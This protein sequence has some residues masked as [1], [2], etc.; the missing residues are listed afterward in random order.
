MLFVAAFLSANALL[1]ERTRANALAQLS[2]TNET[3]GGWF[4][5]YETLP[6]LYARNPRV[7]S[8]L[9]D[10]AGRDELDALNRELAEWNQI[11]GTSDTYLIARDGTTVAASNW[12]LITTFVG[13]NFSYRP[14]FADAISGRPGHF[15]G[16]G[17]TSGQRGYYLSAPIQRGDET[18]GVVVV[19]V[20]AA[21]L[22]RTLAEAAYP[23]FITDKA[24]VVILST[25]PALRL[26]ALEPLTPSAKAEVARVRS[27]DP[28]TIGPA[29]LSAR[30]QFL[31]VT[32]GT[33]R[34]YLPVERAL[35]RERWTLH[36]LYGIAD[37]R[38]QQW[39]LAVAL[40][41][42]GIAAAALARLSVQ[43]RDRLARKLA[44]RE[45]YRLELERRVADRTADLTSTNAR[46]EIE[47][48]ERRAAEDG[49]RRTQEE[50]VQAGKLAALGQMSAALSHEFNQPLMAIRTYCGN[51]RA[52]HRAGQV[53]RADD[54]LARI[55][56]LTERM[57][58]L[59]KHLT[60]FA[61][62]SDG[63]SEPVDLAVIVDEAL[64]LIEGRL[65]AAHATV[66]VTGKAGGPVVGGMIRLQHVVMNLVVN[67]LDAMPEGREPHVR[68]AIMPQAETVD[69][70][71][72][73][74]GTG[75]PDAVLDKIFDPFFTTKEV[76]LGLG[77]GL[78]IS[79]N[80]VRD[81][82]GTLTAG[83]VP[84]GGARFVLSLRRVLAADVAA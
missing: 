80:I 15:F 7:I 74:N 38:R 68:I 42:A 20:S 17:T 53:D 55:M 2:Q 69:L 49:L 46:L 71:V 51:A 36:L 27:Y 1:V 61:R 10:G 18:I 39:M 9:E 21:A 31:R 43:R 22:E 44:D 73:D 54:T 5:R 25:L 83:N 40:A 79:F 32:G 77:L 81:F 60:R 26:T 16:L 41:A 76:G 29:P 23:I 45:R 59:S 56:R 63:T 6:A 66:E 28:E 3:I 19:K 14:Y 30:S 37:L 48:A 82:G 75:I 50:L 72:E 52:F 70:V 62:K 84:G 33:A 8:A 64:A 57:A 11:A 35:E 12:D 65:Q 67:A 34:T 4:H 78:S 24:G 58:A 47:V 13:R